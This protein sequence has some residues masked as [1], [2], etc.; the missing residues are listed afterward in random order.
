MRYATA[1]LLPL[2]AL[3]AC[4][5]PQESCISQATSSLRQVNSFIAETEG[6]LARGYGLRTEQRVRVVRDYCEG[7]TADGTKV[8]VRCEKN[9]VEDVQVRVPLNLNAERARL[10]SLYEQQQDLQTRAAPV[11]EACR[12]T[13]PE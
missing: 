6:N 3:A 1:I 11:I 2:L 10:E 4:A 8:V 12:A 13:Y 9:E 7:V 5:T